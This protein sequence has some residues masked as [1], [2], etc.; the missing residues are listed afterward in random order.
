MNASDSF[1]PS[2]FNRIFKLL[3]AVI[4]PPLGVVLIWIQPFKSQLLPRLA[5]VAVRLVLSVVLLA[6]TVAYLSK[7]GLVHVE[8]SGGGL[9]KP[10]VSFHNPD[11]DQKALETHRDE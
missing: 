4:I 6:L 5:E 3:A 7:L 10:F 11:D 9:S 1:S 8:M 2:G